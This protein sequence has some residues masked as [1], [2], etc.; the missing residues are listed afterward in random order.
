MYPGSVVTNL[1]QYAAVGHNVAIIQSS[2][3]ENSPI[4]MLIAIFSRAFADLGSAHLQE[5]NHGLL[6]A[7]ITAGDGYLGSN[8]LNFG[9]T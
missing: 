8:R 1:E 5:S 2:F 7:L 4:K 6:D 3:L 9:W